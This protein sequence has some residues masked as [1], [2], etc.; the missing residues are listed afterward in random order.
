[1]AIIFD[2][3]WGGASSN[4][5]ITLE[6]A[7]DLVNTYVMYDD[8]W[9]IVDGDDDTKKKAIVRAAA[10]INA[11]RWRGFKYSE[12][13]AMPFP[14]VREE[15]VSQGRSLIGS[16]AN[17][18]LNLQK[19]RVQIA[20]AIQAVWELKHGGENADRD[21]YLAGKRSSSRSNRFSEGHSYGDPPSSIAPEVWDQLRYYK[22]TG[23]RIV[24]GGGRMPAGSFE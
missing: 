24:R 10:S 23:A 15:D 13:Q 6:E 17:D 4:A 8:P 22:S 11:E 16:H 7:Q 18:F 14:R 5:Y 9:L 21:N 1:M 3:T 2:A 19:R 20:N 12:L